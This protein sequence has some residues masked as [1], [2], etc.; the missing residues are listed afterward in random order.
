MESVETC[1]AHVSVGSSY[2]SCIC[3]L[4]T[5]DPIETSQRVVSTR[6]ILFPLYTLYVIHNTHRMHILFTRFPLESIPNGGAEV[7]TM[8]LMQGLMKRGHTVSFA[9]SCD[10]IIAA[11]RSEG[12]PVVEWDIG[13]PPVTKWNAISFYWRKGGMRR[14]LR[15]IFMK[16]KK[17]DA[18]VMLSMTGKLLLTDI[19][20]ESGA[21]V[22]WI[23]H[24]RVG[25][26]LTHNPWLPLFLKQSALAKVIVVS[27]LSRKIYEK[28]GVSKKRI[29]VIAN[30]VS[31]SSRERVRERGKKKNSSESLG[32]GSLHIG[33]IARLSFEKGV[34]VLLNAV[35]EI[36]DLQLT[37]I[38]QGPEQDA[39]NKMAAR[40][41]SSTS[42]RVKLIP[43]TDD[44]CAFYKGI[45]VLILPSR[46]NDPFGLVAA[47]AMAVGTPVIVTDQCGIASFLVDEKDALIVK[48]NS[49]M[50][51]KEAI[52][53]YKEEGLRKKIAAAG[54]KTAGEKFSVK[55][56]VDCYEELFT[57][58]A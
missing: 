17:V 58:A 18:V 23:E 53:R 21:K 44:V 10:A 40:I 19:A 36:P 49:A 43:H 20:V 24:D 46:D 42:T 33:C 31:L 6:Y 22:F 30:G 38:G 39:V 55:K 32:R 54:Q 29:T 35:A 45:D 8:S 41:N 28:L 5:F 50:E 13:A 25:K 27:D 15:K 4:A 47:E 52:S 9:G 1:G 48:A 12:I 16:V 3:E 51:L 7:Q 11:C 26:W 56:M 2:N 37:L 57:V 14:K 34:D